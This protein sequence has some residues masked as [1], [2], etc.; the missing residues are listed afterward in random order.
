M[1][2][3]NMPWPALFTAA[4]CLTLV[5][6]PVLAQPAEGGE[7]GATDGPL[8]IGTKQ[9]PPFAIR[10]EDGEWRGMAIELWEEVAAEL[11]VE[12]E[13]R[14]TDLEG[15][16]TGLEDG[17]FDAS[18]AALTVTGAREARVDFTHP[19]HSSGLG[20]SVPAVGGPSWARMAR[21]LVHPRFLAG[22]GGLVAILFATGLLVWLFEKRRNA[23]QFPP[24]AR[25]LGHAFWWSAVTMTTVGYGDKAP[26]TVGGRAI[27]LV[28][29]FASVIT[30]SGF[31]AAIASALTVAS[32]GAKV[33]GEDD[34]RTARVT[35]VTGSTSERYL[36]RCCR[37]VEAFEDLPAAIRAVSDG[38]ADA[39]VYDE[40]ILRYLSQQ[41]EGA[42]VEVLPETFERQLY[43]VALPAGSPLREPIN[44]ELL[45]RVA[46]P[47]WQAVLDRYLGE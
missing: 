10:G 34:L 1:R 15:L 20:I 22:V 41:R 30:I 18:V 47:D 17:T 11:G 46:D 7:D 5:C 37:N 42:G 25:G 45:R 39:V 36:E 40:P 26:A 23:E 44:R 13:L 31:T 8:V 6:P 19:F 35:T 9:A 14:E 27:A 4:L 29:M 43:A 33:Q 28:W 32:L 21:R 38:R 24:G 2:K 12:Y 3:M 16:L